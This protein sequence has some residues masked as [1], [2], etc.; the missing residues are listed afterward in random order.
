[1]IVSFFLLQLFLFLDILDG[2]LAR[3]KNLQSAAGK[4]L[5]PFFDITIT[6][7]LMCCFTIGAY[8][9]FNSKDFFYIGL[10]LTG[11][12]LY[13][14]LILQVTG[15]VMED[16]RISTNSSTS[17][18]NS[19]K[20]SSKSLANNPLL[21]PLKKVLFSI[22]MVNHFNFIT[23]IS[24][25]GLF[26]VLNLNYLK[27][28]INLILVGLI[29]TFILTFLSLTKQLLHVVYLSYRYDKEP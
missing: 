15:R 22:P 8:N 10:V 20:L 6:F 2:A 24:L 27:F 13:Y 11:F 3:V 7:L 5:D 26:H 16:I 19:V 18:S 14:Y 25:S 21:S 9:E 28:D 12:V 1:M 17:L 29:F 23:Y 4:W